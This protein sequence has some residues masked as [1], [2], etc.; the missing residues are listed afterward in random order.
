MIWNIHGEPT[1]AAINLQPASIGDNSILSGATI[2]ETYIHGLMIIVDGA[3]TLTLKFGSRTLGVFK[4]AANQTLNMSD[5]AGMDGEP[6]L[7]GELGEAFVIN[8]T[9]GVAITGMIK[10]SLRNY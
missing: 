2:G 4:L 10:T 7:K 1:V 8:S 9:A 5:I 3:T 6:I